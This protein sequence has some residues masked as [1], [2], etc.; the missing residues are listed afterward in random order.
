MQID[1][2][3]VLD[4]LKQQG[5]HDRAAEADRELPQQVDTE[6]HGGLLERFGLSP[7]DLAQR[8]MGGGSGGSGGGGIG[9][10]ISGM[11]GGGGR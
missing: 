6:Q 5:Q 10:A 7:A 2:N 4:L 3:Q 11:T 1:K 8:F 9:G